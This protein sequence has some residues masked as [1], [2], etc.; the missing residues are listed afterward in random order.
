MQVS[1]KMKIKNGDNV[2]ENQVR[3]TLKSSIEQ[4]DLLLLVTV[5]T[6]G[7]VNFHQ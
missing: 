1:L 5:Y 7:A 6:K 3:T 2:Q 4:F